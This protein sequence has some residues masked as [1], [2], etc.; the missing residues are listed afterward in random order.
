MKN[1]WESAI[2]SA[3]LIV[4]F[5]FALGKPPPTLMKKK[6]KFSSY[7]RKFIGIGYKVIYD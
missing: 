4:N 7:I 6:I 2:K 1:F 3:V 5:L